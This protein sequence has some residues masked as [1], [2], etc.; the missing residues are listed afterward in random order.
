VSGESL[1]GLVASLAALVGAVF[2]GLVALRHAGR[3]VAAA[4]VLELRAHR[5]AWNWSTRTIY[6]LLRILGENDIDE[7]PGVKDDLARH[8]AN[9]DNPHLALVKKEE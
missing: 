2:T 1:V 9:I 5:D 4:D 8:Q 7:P 6:R 3:D